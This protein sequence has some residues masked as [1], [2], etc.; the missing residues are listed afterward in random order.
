MKCLRRVVFIIILL[1]VFCVVWFWASPKSVKCEYVHELTYEQIVKEASCTENGQI[2]VMC[3]ICGRR[4]STKKLEP[5]GHEFGGYILI[6]APSANKNGIEARSCVV[7]M[8][9]EYREVVCSHKETNSLTITEATCT[10]NGKKNLVCIDCDTILESNVVE[11]H[12]HSFGDYTILYSPS[13]NKN[14]MKIRSCTKCL[15]QEK[16]EIVCKHEKTKENVT[17]PTCNN[18][19]LKIISCSACKTILEKKTLEKLNHSYGSWFYEKEATPLDKGTRY[20][21]CLYCGKTLSEDYEFSAPGEDYI[22]IPGTGINACVT[23]GSLTQ[24]A[25]N[26]YDIVYTEDLGKNDP[27]VMGHNYR[28]LESLYETKIGNYI[29]V[30]IDGKIEIYEVVVSEFA[31]STKNN[32]YGQKTGTSIYRNYGCKT[33]HLYTCYGYIVDHRWIVLAIK[34]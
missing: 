7:C 30:C 24:D 9:K 14:G 20:K 23:I 25:V 21:Q 1:I 19:G 33:L 28:S 12:G 3:D 16:C 6:N 2:D 13:A 10:K 11:P 27:F 29:Y 5:L 8:K 32:I 34:L 22:Y 31:L 17:D 15:Q 4:V 26:R 18:K